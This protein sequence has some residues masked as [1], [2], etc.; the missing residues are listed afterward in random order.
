M[1]GL[2]ALG[3]MRFGYADLK[4]DMNLDYPRAKFY[5]DMSEKWGLDIGETWVH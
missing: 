2:D 1:E 4:Y 5:N 3:K